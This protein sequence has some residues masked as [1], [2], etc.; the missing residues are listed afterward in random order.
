MQRRIGQH[1]CLPK[2]L[3][4]PSLITHPRFTQ[5]WPVVIR[6]FHWHALRKPWPPPAKTCKRG[7]NI[8]TLQFAEHRH[9]AHATDAVVTGVREKRLAGVSSVTFKSSINFV[10]SSFFNQPRRVHQDAEIGDLAGLVPNRP[11]DRRKTSGCRRRSRACVPAR[12]KP[13]HADSLDVDA[14]LPR[15]CGAN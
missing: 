10:G 5:R 2:S 13:K 7:R 14:F 6:G 8:T 12:G 1:V 4:Q 11:P 3:L 9:A 15:R